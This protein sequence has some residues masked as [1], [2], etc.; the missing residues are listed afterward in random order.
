[1]IFYYVRHG[2]PIY[3][4]NS[5]TEYGKEQ[6]EALAKRFELYGLDEIY[7]S[8]STR[9]AQTAEPTC[10]LLNIEPVFLDWTNED[11]AWRDFTLQKDGGRRWLFQ[12]YESI[13][14]MASR[15]M[16]S[17]GHDY[18][19]DPCFDNTN[20][21]EVSKQVDEKIDDF[22]LSLGFK[23]NREKGGYEVVAPNSKRVAL[24]AHQGFGMVFLSSVLDIPYP[25]FCT[26]FDIGHSGVTVI[27]FDETKEFA[28]PRVLQLSND[29]HLYKEG[30]LKGYQGWIDI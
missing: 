30:I 20:I 24:F 6:A 19:K 4:P 28:Y 17:L 1:M 14:K 22:F 8:P 15:E 2:E 9:A 10:K 23:H 11:H 29:S 21:R 13:E 16:L 12:D 5:L 3:S 26:K 7:S 18:A 27:Y 25:L